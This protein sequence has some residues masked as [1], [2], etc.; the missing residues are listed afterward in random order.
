LERSAS[1]AQSLSSMSAAAARCAA[2]PGPFVVAV[3]CPPGA[4]ALDH[5]PAIDGVEFIV[6]NTLMDF[7]A[8]PSL[9]ATQAL[10]FIATGG[11]PALMSPLLDICPQA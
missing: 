8:A 5:L 6:A 1:Q 7:Q 11:D 4:P 3:V 2:A 10:M 9:P